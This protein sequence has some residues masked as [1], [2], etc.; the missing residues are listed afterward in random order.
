MTF[1]N[2]VN[3][4]GENLTVFAV[5]VSYGIFRK[6]V[7]A[8]FT[9]TV[10]VEIVRKTRFRNFSA[11]VPNFFMRTFVCRFVNFSV[12]HMIVRVRCAVGI[13]A[14]TANRR[15][16]T[17]C[18]SARVR[19]NCRFARF[20]VTD[21]VF[22]CVGMS[23]IHRYNHLC[24]YIAGFVL[25]NNGLCAFCRIQC[26]FSV[27]IECYGCAVYGYFIDI[28]F[29]NGYCLFG[30]VCFAVFDARNYRCGAVKHNA[31]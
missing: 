22:V 8:I 28:F 27:F 6:F 25:Y 12:I 15:G 3:F 2:G 30:A 21:M 5:G 4:I 17:R 19:R 10:F 26:E 29:R 24:G 1:N 7:T 14:I 16:F 20:N 31:V 23:V 18:R 11:T 13:T 9:N